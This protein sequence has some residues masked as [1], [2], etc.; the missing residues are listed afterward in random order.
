[1]HRVK[2]NTRSC[3][4]KQYDKSVYFQKRI[5]L[6]RLVESLVQWRHAKGFRVSSM[7]FLILPRIW[8]MR[9]LSLKF[10]SKLRVV[11]ALGEICWSNNNFVFLLSFFNG[12]YEWKG[13]GKVFLLLCIRMHQIRWFGWYC[14]WCARDDVYGSCW[15]KEHK[16][17]LKAALKGLFGLQQRAL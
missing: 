3:T 9:Y 11:E 5:L 13:N 2:G 17:L 15:A 1:M 4:W 8:C 10:A 7:C 16:E 14:C 6:W 12:F